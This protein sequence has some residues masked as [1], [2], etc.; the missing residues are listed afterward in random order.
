MLKFQ[1]GNAK[2]NKKIATFSL[3][4]GHTCP[5][6]KDCFSK[7]DKVTGKIVDGKHCQYRCFAA[8]DES[9][10]PNVRKAR[11]HN[12]NLLKKAKSAGS[13]A[14][15]LHEAVPNIPFV[16]VHVSGDFF[17]KNYF[18]AWMAVA[19]LKR[20]Q[21]FYAYT[22]AVK[23]IVKFKKDIPQNFRLVASR[24]GTD[25]HLIDEHNLVCAEVVMSEAEAEKKGLLLDHDDSMAIAATKSFGLLIHGT[26]PANTEAGKAWQIVKAAGKGYGRKRKCTK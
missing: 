21:L 14:G 4:A 20:N 2:L 8:S 26:Q 11:W 12:F 5:F 19:R 15:L 25:D 13:M 10:L 9:R 7:A 1:K 22:K 6:A 16:R 23:H 18:H 17:N 3:P 24:G